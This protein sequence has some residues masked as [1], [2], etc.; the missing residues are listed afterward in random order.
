VKRIDRITKIRL[1]LARFVFKPALRLGLSDQRQVTTRSLR[2][3]WFRRA[4]A[5]TAALRSHEVRAEGCR[6]LA[7][8]RQ[9]R[10]PDTGVDAVAGCADE[11]N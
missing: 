7:E 8:V 10:R 4:A 6:I 3:E 9:R 11:R 2:N 1:N 5:G